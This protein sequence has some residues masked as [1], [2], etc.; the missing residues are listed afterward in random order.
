MSA[1]R[2]ILPPRLPQV[3][4]AATVLCV[5]VGLLGGCTTTEVEPEGRFATQGVV[6]AQPVDQVWAAVQAALPGARQAG[7]PMTART[8]V[9]GTVVEA[10]VQRHSSGGTILDVNSEDPAAAERVQL[11]I[12]RMLLR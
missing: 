11:A 2:R 12:Q 3:L 1:A 9:G 6:V 10:R 4:V 7:G 5:G 8:D